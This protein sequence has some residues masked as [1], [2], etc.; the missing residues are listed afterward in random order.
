MVGNIL[1]AQTEAHGLFSKD[2]S[3][4]QVLTKASLCVC[5]CV[6]HKDIDIKTACRNIWKRQ[7]NVFIE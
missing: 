2:A 3:I 7:R 1:R 6:N 4:H 5:M